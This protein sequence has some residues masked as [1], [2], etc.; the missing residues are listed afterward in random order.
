MIRSFRGP[1]IALL[2]A[3]LAVVLLSRI[4]STLWI[5]RALP[6]EI[7][8]SVIPGLWYNFFF[9]LMV[10]VG[11]S[12]ALRWLI[13]RDRKD[14]SEKARLDH[15]AE[16]ATM[17]GG[18]AHEARNLLHALQTRIE[19]LRKSAADD[20]KSLE[21]VNKLDELAMDMEQLFTDFLSLAR[22]ANDHLE[23]SNV[24]NLVNQV[25]EFEDL[26]LERSG[27]KI[28]R[29]FDSKVPQV[30][31]DRGKFKRALLNLIV[32]AR[33][34]LP[35]GGTLWVRT[36]AYGKQVRIEV[37]DNGCGIPLEDQPRIF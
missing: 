18:F 23:E 26:E 3:A 32:N 33:H 8:R 9:E 22:P 7:A 29:E 30:L 6:E 16:V 36:S 25:I 13:G 4:V 20:A 28:V 37:E 31:V 12:L 17:S 1:I 2:T 34:A 14:R 11:I 24:T 15:L 21:R 19:L 35:E 10:F 5:F 27:V